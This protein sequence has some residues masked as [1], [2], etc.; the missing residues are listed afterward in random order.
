MKF[1]LCII[2]VFSTTRFLSQNCKG[3]IDDIISRAKLIDSEIA[4]YKKIEKYKD[5][6]SFKNYYVLNDTIQKIEISTVE[7]FTL[8]RVNWYYHHSNLIYIEQIW[9]DTLNEKIIDSQKIII[10][11]NKIIAWLNTNN[12]LIDFNTNEYN[13]LCL[14]IIEYGLYQKKL[15]EAD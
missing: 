6:T 13:Q 3:K 9:S 14:Q 10:Q 8:K 11:S 7:K 12:Q 5:S 15:M 2:I 4:A 1:F